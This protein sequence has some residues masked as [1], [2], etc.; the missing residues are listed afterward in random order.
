MNELIEKIWYG[1]HPLR[2][3]LLP[4]SLIYKQVVWVR[5]FYLKR[6]CTKIFP[7]PIIVV[8]NL[9]VGGAGKTPL[10]IALAQKLRERGLRVGIVS[11]GY[12]ASVKQFPY[13]VKPDANARLAGDEP[14]LLARRTQCPVVIDP[15]RVR[16][17]QYLMDTYQSQIILSD[18]GLQHYALGR[19]LEIMVID[20]VRGLGNG[21]CLPAGPLREDVSRLQQAHFLIAN[22]GQWPG[23]FT[24]ELMPGQLTQLT[25]GKPLPLARLTGT[26]A[27]IAGIGHPQRFY[28]TL[29]KLGVAFTPYSFPDHH[30]Y[31]QEE[32]CF[33]EKT[34]VMTE[35]DAVKCQA[36]ATDEMYFLPV[37][38]QVNNAFW[39]ALWSHEQLQGYV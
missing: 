39:D 10:V 5:R 38:A 25:S 7:I 28:N 12:G 19:A 11:R 36:F 13:E 8:G 37:E 15:K 20:G 4:F 23:A 14:L 32:L 21:M 18:D 9:T 1:R 26:V 35:K 2:W 16:A 27:A 34:L 17:V 29:S 30:P 22:G 24:M 33:A 6:F 31:T 3:F